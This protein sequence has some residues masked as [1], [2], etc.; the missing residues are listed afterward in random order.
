MATNASP[1][2]VN[3]IDLQN[4][5]TDIRGTNLT[6][7]TTRLQSQVAN[8]QTMINPVTHTIYADTLSNFTTGSKINIV[9]NLNLSNAGLYSNGTLLNLSTTTTSINTV[10]TYTPDNL[11]DW[12]LNA[13]PSTINA[14]FDILA[15]YL[16]ANDTAAWQAVTYS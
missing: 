14:A 3:I 4:I 1:F 6:N 10:N 2:V 16:N 9:S 11:N 15:K 8:L 5:S 12:P 7:A 13:K